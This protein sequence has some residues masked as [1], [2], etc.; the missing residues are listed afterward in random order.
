MDKTLKEKLAKLNPEK[1]AAFLQQEAAINPEFMESVERL[2]D[3]DLPDKVLDSILGEIES[4]GRSD[5]FIDWRGSA[6]FS[7]TL[8]RVIYN[9]ETLLLPDSAEK[10]L[11]ALDAFLEIS[12]NVIER[13]DDSSGDVGSQ[14]RYAVDVWGKAWNLLPHFDGSKLAIAIWDYFDN[15]DYG[16]Y[17]D[18]ITAAGDALKRHGLNELETLVKSK[19]TSEKS[20]FS[21][22]H[23]L[24]DIALLRQ[25]PEDFLAAFK[26]TKKEMNVSDQLELAR[27]YIDTLRVD[28]AIRLL[29]SI[30]SD[31]DAHKRL[32]LLIEAYGIK[33]ET[34]IVQQLRWDGF[35]KHHR[36]DL[37]KSYYDSLLSEQE[38]KNAIDTAIAVALTWD[39]IGSLS[40]LFE[41]NHH[42]K[43][44]DL[45]HRRYASLTGHQYY[46]LKDFAEEFTKSGFP[47]EAILIYRRLTED[48]L[49][50]AQSKYYHH[51]I[52]YL[53][54]SKQISTY[55]QDW[56]NYQTTASYFNQLKEQHR[57][58]PSF[59]Q[60]F[61][62]I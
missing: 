14:F 42:D 17:D 3:H 24:H 51:A 55:V 23:A 7:Q 52:N 30:K 22:Y 9:I 29:E 45:L 60:K 56:K 20:K 47:L 12:Q 16:L 62:L 27:L 38:K 32:D 31:Y 43:A 10:A 36:K 28:E 11:K 5:E 44:A 13:A 49:A 6:R 40:M 39:T 4:I 2:A 54:S 8:A 35:V 41:L 15:N 58:K 50:R 21:L 19:C 57:R 34:E 18:M 1:L 26:L 25:S 61:E 48:I 59:M 33:D 37:F 46:T 53:K